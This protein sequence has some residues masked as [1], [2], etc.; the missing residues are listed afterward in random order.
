[1]SILELKNVTKIFCADE[2]E[3]NV[4]DN[5]NLKVEEGEIIATR[6]QAKVGEYLV[7]D[8]KQPAIIS[9]E[10][11]YTAREKQSKNPRNPKSTKVR[12]AFAGLIYC[13]CGKT[14][15]LRYYKNPDGS[16]RNPPRL[17]CTNQADCKTGSCLYTDMFEQVSAILKQCIE[18]FEV[19]LDNDAGDSAKLHAKLISTLEKRMKDIEAKELAQ[20]ESQSNPDPAQRMP[21]EIFKKLNEKLLKE[22]EEVRQALCKAYESMPEPV[23]Y[24]EKVKMFSDALSALNNPSASAEEKNRLLKKCIKRIDYK[25]ERPERIKSQQIRFYDPS[26]KRSRY[27]S[28]LTTGANWT[29]TP[30]ELDVK[31]TVD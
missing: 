7:Y 25:R 31:L 8:G 16:E 14:L 2:E 28:P 17:L 21:A 11:F 5:I 18:D 10:L 9:E 3:V 23:D 19:R 15:T 13:Q 30:I 12:N 26:I 20:W 27:Q 22:K 4:L 1:M 6:P 24:A 29:V